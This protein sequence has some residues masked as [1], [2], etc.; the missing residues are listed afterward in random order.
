MRAIRFV[1]VV[2]IALL[3]LPFVYDAVWAQSQTKIFDLATQK[4]VLTTYI[5]TWANPSTSRYWARWNWDAC[6]VVHDPNYVYPNGK[7]DIA[8]LLSADWTIRFERR[9]CY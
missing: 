1:L 8:C 3:I 4:L 6:G 9:I 7:H 5:D 2:A